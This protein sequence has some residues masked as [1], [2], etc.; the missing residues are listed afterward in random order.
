MVIQWYPGHMTKAKRMLQDNLKIADIV[1]VILDA[2]IPAASWN[3]DVTQIIRDKEKV[4]LLNKADLAD[5]DTTNAWVHYYKKAGIDAIPVTSTQKGERK[6]IINAIE[7][8]ASEKVE[9]MKARGVKKIVRVMVLGVP[10]VGKSTLINMISGYNVTKTENRPGVTRGRQWIRINPY[11]ELMDTPG[12]LWPKF[13]DE[14]TGLHLAYCGSINEEILDTEKLSVCLLDELKM[15]NP[16][17]LMSRYNL[18]YLEDDAERVLEQICKARGF[19]RKGGEPDIERAVNTL[20]D[21]FKQG[22]LGR[23]S[24]EKPEILQ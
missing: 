7:K 9:R 12:L 14:Q 10:N 11:L 4:I 17:A 1:V 22:K 15:I 6:K 23:I 8:A 5:M 3:P 20:L 21:E 16:Q 13:D 2:R 18:D 24:L 19:V